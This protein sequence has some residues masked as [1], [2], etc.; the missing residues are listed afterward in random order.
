MCMFTRFTYTND[1]DD[2]V[3]DDDDNHDNTNTHN[4]ETDSNTTQVETDSNTTQVD[5]IQVDTIQVDTIQ[6]ETQTEDL[7]SYLPVIDGGSL[8]H[9][10]PW[11]SSVPYKNLS[12][13]YCSYIKNHYNI[14]NVVGFDGYLEETTKSNTHRRVKGK[15]K[16]SNP[17][18]FTK[19]MTLSMSKDSFLSNKENK[20]R[21]IH[22]L[23][24]CLSAKGSKVLYSTGDADL[25]LAKTAVTLSHTQRT[26]LHGEDTDLLILLLYHSDI[27]SEPLFFLPSPTKTSS[28]PKTW[29]IN[30]VKKNMTPTTADSLLFWLAVTGCDTTSRVYAL[31]NGTTFKK[32]HDDARFTTIVATF[33]SKTSCHEDVA[34]AGEKALLM[35]YGG[36]PGITLDELRYVKFNEKV[37]PLYSFYSS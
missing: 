35:M 6:V 25:M 37:C 11:P 21:F 29:C 17:I 2:D 1:D 13:L 36:D 31:R 10:V 19:D 9:R 7:G 14:P 5:T 30:S 3:D 33:N 4:D 23:G 28:V 27:D 34:S 15:G 18:H 8:L 32:F 12:Q 22:F 20:T 24:D 26:G 16:T